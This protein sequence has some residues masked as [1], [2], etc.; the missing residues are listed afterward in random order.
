MSI[1]EE[2][3]PENCVWG[4]PAW[5]PWRGAGELGTRRSKRGVPW[6]AAEGGITKWGVR[7]GLGGPQPLQEE[8]LWIGVQRR[9]VRQG[10]AHAV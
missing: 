5:S 1:E 4:A 6:R 2:K 10:A 9:E 7:T 3:M 8:L